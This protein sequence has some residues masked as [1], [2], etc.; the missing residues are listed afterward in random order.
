M[1]RVVASLLLLMLAV[2]HT[3][4]QAQAVVFSVFGDL[5]PFGANEPA[6]LCLTGVGLLSLAFLGRPAR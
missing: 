3:P 5:F 4:S 1:R 2:I 6:M